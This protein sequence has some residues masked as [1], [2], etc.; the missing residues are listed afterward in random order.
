M[1]RLAQLVHQVSLASRCRRAPALA[2]DDKQ[3]VWEFLCQAIASASGRSGCCQGLRLQVAL[4]NGN[5][6][7][8]AE[9]RRRLDLAGP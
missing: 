9:Y 4:R 3:R 5:A 1:S 6:D 7:L 8:A 2:K